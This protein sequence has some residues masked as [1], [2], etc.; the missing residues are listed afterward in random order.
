VVTVAAR[1]RLL[2]IVAASI[3]GACGLPAAAPP[4]RQPLA[5]AVRAPPASVSPPARAALPAS[6]AAPAASSAPP[7]VPPPAPPPLRGTQ[8]IVSGQHFI[9]TV[10]VDDANVYFETLDDDAGD[11]FGVV[12]RTS[13]SDGARTTLATPFR[14]Y[15]L[16]LG[17]SYVYFDTQGGASSPWV[18]ERIPKAGGALERCAEYQPGSDDDEWSADDRGVVVRKGTTLLEYPAACK[19]APITVTV[20]GTTA[21]HLHLDGATA[22]VVVDDQLI[23]VA[24]AS[25]A[26]KTLAESCTGNPFVGDDGVYWMAGGD[27]AQAVLW[28]VARSG[29]PPATVV[30]M[31]LGVSGVALDASHVYWVSGATHVLRRAPRAGGAAED[32]GA[33]GPGARGDILLDATSVYW[34]DDDLSSIRRAPKQ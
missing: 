11:G 28:R 26:Q 19:G 3:A 27:D 6:A 20:R 5:S 14:T 2:A 13:K 7:P 8:T 31:G 18:V 1:V 15:G 24:R 4:A 33:L 25:G 23:A 17:G 34:V 32:L 10:A 12:V 9:T 30:Q 22:Y 21:R 29:G 16:Y